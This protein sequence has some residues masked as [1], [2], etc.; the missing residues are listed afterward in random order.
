M[1]T[2]WTGRMRSCLL[3]PRAKFRAQ[4]KA[5]ITP[6]L[7]HPSQGCCSG[8]VPRQPGRYQGGLDACVPV[9]ASPAAAALCFR[10]SR[11]SLR[12]Q[13]SESASRSDS[14][15]DSCL[16]QYC[17]TEVGRSVLCNRPTADVIPAAAALQVL[18]DDVR[19]SG[20]MSD[21]IAV[22]Q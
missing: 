22:R 19:R 3:M 11:R 17:L 18:S 14:Q 8:I 15:S 9:G 6:A 16:I 20:Q 21:V 2:R 10:R 1:V 13:V 7:W 5:R 12:A 4:N